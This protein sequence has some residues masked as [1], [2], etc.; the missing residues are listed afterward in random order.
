MLFLKISDGHSKLH[1]RDIQVNIAK[2]S[3][4][5][6]NRRNNNR[7]NGE[8]RGDVRD[9]GERGG[10]VPEIDGSKFRGG[11]RNAGRGNEQ[12]GRGSNEQRERLQLK[13]RS[14]KPSEVDKPSDQ[15]NWRSGS[16]DR[17]SGDRGG[18]GRGR[19]RGRQN[20]RGGDRG[21]RGGKKNTR[22]NDKDTKEV[23]AD[24][25]DSAPKTTKKTVAAPVFVKEEKKKVAKVSNAF[26][27]LGFESDSD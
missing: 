13:P 6:N 10:N 3:T 12:R 1:N 20:S 7:D 14:S 17:D 26:A 27:A 19:G 23:S 4:S 25:W 21:G 15:G 5:S 9:H 24:G 22:N 8:R 18:R 11:F 16:S 2:P